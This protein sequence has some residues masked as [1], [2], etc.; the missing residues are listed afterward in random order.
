MGVPDNTKLP[1][2]RCVACGYDLAGLG[3]PTVCPECGADPIVP[4]GDPDGLVDLM[5]CGTSFEA[6]VIAAG[7]RDEGIGAEAWTSPV[8]VVFPVGP[9]APVKVQVR[10][11]DVRR[12]RDIVRA[13]HFGP[14]DIDWSEVDTGDT[15]PLTAR[16]LNP[17]APD[18]GGRRRAARRF[19]RVVVV[20]TALLLALSFLQRCSPLFGTPPLW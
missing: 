2:D 18:A 6:E 10:R 4:P 3:E 15:S 1:S 16:E 5:P 14:S 13:K 12:A 7:L 20:L 11:R 17:A 8:Q 19:G 9:A